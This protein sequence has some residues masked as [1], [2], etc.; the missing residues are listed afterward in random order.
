KELIQYIFKG[1]MHCLIVPA[2]K[3]HFMEE[4]ALKLYF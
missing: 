1:G 4:E 3:L 2:K